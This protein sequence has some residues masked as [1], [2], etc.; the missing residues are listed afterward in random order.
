[1]PVLDHEA[2]FGAEDGLAEGVEEI[3]HPEGSLLWAPEKSAE[4]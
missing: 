2:L 3:D 1:M 4:A